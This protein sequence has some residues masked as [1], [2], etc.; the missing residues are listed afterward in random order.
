MFFGRLVLHRAMQQNTP[1]CSVLAR[2]FCCTCVCHNSST[3][4]PLTAVH[5]FLACTTVLLYRWALIS[6]VCRPCCM[7]VGGCERWST[8]AGHVRWSADTAPYHAAK[9]ALPRFPYP[10]TDLLY[11]RACHSYSSTVVPLYMPIGWVD[12]LV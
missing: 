8:R 9:K 1:Q 7:S 6:C 4:V 10:P 5:T 12:W 2:C 11:T 3:A